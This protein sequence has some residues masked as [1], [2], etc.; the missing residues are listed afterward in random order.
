MQGEVG[1]KKNIDWDRCTLLCVSRYISI[2][3]TFI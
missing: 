3:L 2:V 1:H